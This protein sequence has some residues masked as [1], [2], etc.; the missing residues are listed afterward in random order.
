MTRWLVRFGYDGGPF[1]GW[2]R[3]PGL[4]TVEGEILGGVVRCGIA[5]SPG[6]VELEVASRTDRGVSARGNVLA[7]TSRLSGPAVLRALNGIAPEIFFYEA[8]EMPESLRVRAARTREYRYFLFEPEPAL[9]AWSAL[10]PM[11]VGRPIDVRSF[12]RGVPAGSPCWRTLERLTLERAP[13]GGVLRV[14]A[15]GF[16]WGMVRKIVA[17]LASSARGELSHQDLARAL[18]GELRLSVPLAAPEPLVLWNVE[19][20]IPFDHRTV[21]RT[22][23]Q[24]RYLAGALE[25]ARGRAVVLPSLDPGPSEPASG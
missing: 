12:A 21:H 5:P 6:A 23:S 2:A 7:L 1:M 18:A 4:R 16:L 25:H 11:F 14:E 3:Q 8:T 17:A 22:R 20:G 10:L 9:S 15:R 13:W 19:Y 24:Q